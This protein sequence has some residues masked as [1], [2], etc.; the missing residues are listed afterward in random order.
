M[1][2]SDPGG[3]ATPLTPWGVGGQKILFPE[4]AQKYFCATQKWF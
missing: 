3:G 2:L 1:I 4:I